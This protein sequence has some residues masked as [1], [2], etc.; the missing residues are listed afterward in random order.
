MRFVKRYRRLM[1][2]RALKPASPIFVLDAEEVTAVL[3]EG[4]L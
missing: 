2:N 3:A 1:T 4:S